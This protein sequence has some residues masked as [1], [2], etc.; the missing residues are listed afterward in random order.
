M[1]EDNC[2]FFYVF[3]CAEQGPKDAPGFDFSDNLFI[4]ERTEHTAGSE[5]SEKIRTL[6]QMYDLSLY[7]LIEYPQDGDGRA[8]A[9]L[10]LEEHTSGPYTVWLARDK[11]RTVRFTVYHL[12]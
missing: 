10:Y 11:N 4:G 6:S 3:V 1:F 12:T 9:R 2:P 7:E 8:A 5:L